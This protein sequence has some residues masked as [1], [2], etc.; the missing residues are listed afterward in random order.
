MR[1][2]IHLAGVRELDNINFYVL[3]ALTEK[4]EEFIKKLNKIVEDYRGE[5]SNEFISFSDL[6]ELETIWK[7]YQYLKPFQFRSDPREKMPDVFKNKTA[8]II[9]T[10]WKS[11]HLTCPDDDI[12]KGS[13]A[14]ARI[15]SE[16]KIPYP[17]EVKQKA[18][19]G[20]LN[21]LHASYPDA[22]N[23]LGF[24]EQHIF[25]YLEGKWEFRWEI[26]QKCFY[27]Q[28]DAIAI[29]DSCSPTSPTG[30]TPEKP[31]CEDCIVNSIGINIKRFLV[32]RFEA[33]RRINYALRKLKSKEIKQ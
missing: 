26:I 3:G 21:Y 1:E 30:L 9:W 33:E 14:A 8:F 7:K 11:R 23:E 25:P 29:C 19:K 12:E 5:K 27:C 6:I 17:K 4:E 22:E 2:I 20:F 16:H 18:V 10:T 28:K 24:W 32:P 31:L 15:L 13:L